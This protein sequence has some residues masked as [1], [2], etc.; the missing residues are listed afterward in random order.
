MNPT[1]NRM[2]GEL[3]DGGAAEQMRH[4]DEA[5]ARTPRSVSGTGSTSR[6]ESGLTAVRHGRHSKMVK[7]PFGRGAAIRLRCNPYRAE[8]RLTVMQ[9]RNRGELGKVVVYA[10]CSNHPA[11]PP[12][13]G[14]ELPFAEHCANV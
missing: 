9:H 14:G 7:R 11:L 6:A 1:V 12:V 8:S 13:M 4:F 3:P 5:D 2:G 10:Q